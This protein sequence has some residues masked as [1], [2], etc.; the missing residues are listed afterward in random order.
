MLQFLCAAFA[1]AI[2]AGCVTDAG[3]YSPEQEI[4]EQEKYETLEI[5]T[6]EGRVQMFWGRIRA[7]GQVFVMRHGLSPHDQIAPVGMTAGCILGEGR[8]LNA[9][10][11]FEARKLGRILAEQQAPIRKAFASDMCR[12]W[13]TARLVAGGAE[14]VAHPAQKT[15]NPQIIAAFKK[16]IEAMLANEPGATFLLVSHSNVAPL[17]G[18]TVCDD[19]DELP[20][21]VISVV[22]PESWTSIARI[23]PDGA[24]T[25]CP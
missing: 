17:Y 1:A 8:G 15:K 5:H 16:E 7:G 23:L 21:G 9:E 3:L 25:G 19:E 18:A 13:D 4:G 6:P 11:L 10:G 12:A 22:S 24:V 2:L 14:T 20:E